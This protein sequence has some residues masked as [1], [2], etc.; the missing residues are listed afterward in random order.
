MLVTRTNLSEALWDRRTELG[1][2]RAVVAE[3]A[4]IDPS[5]LLRLEKGDRAPFFATVER[6]AAVLDMD[7]MVGKDGMVITWDGKEAAA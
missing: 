2:T 7:V 4:N 1:M 5:A 3:K 6:L